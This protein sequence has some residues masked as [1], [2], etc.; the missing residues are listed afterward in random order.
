MTQLIPG[1]VVELNSGGPPMAVIEATFPGR[2]GIG[3]SDIV[4]WWR[5]GDGKPQIMEI[6]SRCVR[7]SCHRKARWLG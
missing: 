6:D 1:D 3:T 4:V 7:L 2:D 5:S